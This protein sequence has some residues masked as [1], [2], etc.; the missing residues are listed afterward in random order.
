MTVR[1]G[2]S[3]WTYAGWRGVFYPPKLPQKRELAYAASQV[4]SIEIN[5]TFYSLQRPSSFERWRDETPD[6]FLFAVKGPRFLTHMKKLVGVEA[7][8][9]NF[10]ASGILALNDKLGPVLWQL[11]ATFK[12]DAGRMA[13]FFALLPR[14]TAQARTLARRHEPRMAGRAYLKID[15]NRPLRHA[16]EPR[17]DSFIEPASLEL[18]RRHNIAMVAAD[19]SRWARYHADTADFAYARLHG[20]EET[21][22]SGYDD[23]QL[24]EWA[25]WVRRASKDGRDV[26]V[27]F[28][29]DAK[30]RAPAD[31]VALLRLLDLVTA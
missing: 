12:F 15:E 19:S 2:L 30:V 14:D 29:N 26:F 20:G 13:A 1:I 4:N 11:P 28:D 16:L 9:A 10:F 8:L 3:G 22:V 27:Y 24:R 23:K 7:A 21:Y 5:G 18:L 17:H 31:A 25:R 6:D